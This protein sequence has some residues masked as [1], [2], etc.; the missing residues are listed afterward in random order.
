MTAEATLGDR[1]PRAGLCGLGSR[2]LCHERAQTSNDVRARPTRVRLDDTFSGVSPDCRTHGVF[3]RGP[4]WPGHVRWL[5]RTLNLRQAD[6][7]FAGQ[8]VK[9]ASRMAEQSR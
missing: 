3:R 7:L 6:D 9:T 8:P 4:Q 1:D 5:V 2:R